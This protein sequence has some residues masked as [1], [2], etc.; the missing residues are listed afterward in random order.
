M[1]RKEVF[2]YTLEDKFSMEDMEAR[3]LY[4]SAGINEETAGTIIYHILRYNRIDRDVPVEER[5]P[6]IIY[7][8]SPGGS[9]VDGYA[10]IDVMQQSVTPV[11]TVNQGICASM[12]FLIFL[13]G[14]KRYSMLRSEFLMHDGSTYGWDSTAKMKDRMDFET[15]QIEAMTKKYIMDRTKIN[16]DL[17]DAKYR[18][19]WYFLPEEAKYHGVV[20]Y[21]VGIDCSMNEIL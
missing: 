9:V 11:Y 1:E 13:A 20:D 17:Y 8:N 5:Q 19:E 6:I 15:G 3:R 16:S 7:I 12:G 4:L 14:H 10:L 18:V 21:I 2:S